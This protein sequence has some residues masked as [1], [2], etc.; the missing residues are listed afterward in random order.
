MNLVEWT[1]EEW[2]SENDLVP[3]H[4]TLSEKRLYE[5][6]TFDVSYNCY[7]DQMQTWMNDKGY[8]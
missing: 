7:M 4:D 2:S 1:P 6:W 5:A 3:S 8:M